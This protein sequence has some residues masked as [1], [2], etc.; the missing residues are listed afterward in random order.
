MFPV[1]FAPHITARLFGVQPQ[2][3]AAAPDM[4]DWSRAP[5]N[6]LAAEA[7]RNAD[8]RAALG[9][10][11]EM[12]FQHLVNQ[13]AKASGG[14]VSLGQLSAVSDIA[15]K[16]TPKQKELM[17]KD[18][19]LSRYMEF[20]DKMLEKSLAEADEVAKV[21]PKAAEQI[22][23]NAW[24]KWQQQYQPLVGADPSIA[25]YLNREPE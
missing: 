23:Q 16:T 8:L 19:A 9:R 6:P 14:K 18:I 15:A 4:R 1:K 2:A 11:P 22:G 7:Y 17:P 10:G 21:D 25:Q 3:P 20:A 5:V 12:S 24:M 13:V